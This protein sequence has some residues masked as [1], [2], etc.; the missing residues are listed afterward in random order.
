MLTTAINR[1]TMS[2]RQRGL[3]L[4]EL[5]VGITVGLIVAAGASMVAVNQI[6]EH[7][8]LMLETQ[9]QQDLRTTADILQQDLRRAGFRGRAELGVWAPPTDVGTLGETAALTAS[10]NQ[11]TALVKTDNAS[12]R[13]LTYQYARPSSGSDYSETGVLREVEHFGFKWDKREGVQELYLLVGAVGGE[14]WQPI[15]DRASVKIKG[16]DIDIDEQSVY[17][18]EFCDKPCNLPPATTGLCPKH[19]VRKVR[20]TIVG[21]A[22]HDSNVKRTL[23]GVERLRA[24]EVIGACPA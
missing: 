8:R 15:T 7:R 11:F 21:E 20:F 9:I 10:V 13:S 5:M 1:T 14:N 12:L 22:A 2:V 3:G 24:D 19:V 6:N 17:V 18:G 23:S 4:V 16:F